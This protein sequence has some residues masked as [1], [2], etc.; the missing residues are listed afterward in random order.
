MTVAQT[1]WGTALADAA[2]NLAQRLDPNRG[3]LE[4]SAIEQALEFESITIRGNNPRSVLQS[5]LNRQQHR[6]RR[7]GRGIWTWLPP[8]EGGDPTAGLSG[9]DLE[10]AA[11]DAARSMITSSGTFH[12]EDLKARLLRDGTTIKGPNQ[13]QTIRR[14]M[15]TSSKFELV[16]PGKGVF[17]WK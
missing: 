9:K 4:I 8:N 10:D 6:F 14:I 2:H 5:A 13:G 16:E 12:Y 3:G 17:R 11:Y 15:Q 7:T 1:L